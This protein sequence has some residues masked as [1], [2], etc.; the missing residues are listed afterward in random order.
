MMLLSNITIGGDL[1]N[2]YLTEQYIVNYLNGK[3]VKNLNIMYLEMIENLF[4]NINLEDK[5]LAWKNPFLQKT[6][7]SLA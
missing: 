4:G 2:G 5:I 3:K 7:L 6:D 1:M